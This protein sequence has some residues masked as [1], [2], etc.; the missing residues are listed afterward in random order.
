MRTLPFVATAAFTLASAIQTAAGQHRYLVP[1]FEVKHSPHPSA[2]GD[3]LWGREA[4]R[5][6]LQ[7]LMMSTDSSE[8]A[9]RR[10]HRLPLVSPD[11]I[12]I[13]TDERICERAARAYYRH[14]LGPRPLGGV[15]VAEVGDLYAVYGARRAGEWTLLDIYTR[16]F[17]LIV[18]VM[19]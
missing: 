19:S 18:S 15:T 6:Q 17:E 2:C 7:L 14:R 13:V 9:N 4:L 3:G 11:S 1:P 8:T 12:H 16:D 10:L 5:F